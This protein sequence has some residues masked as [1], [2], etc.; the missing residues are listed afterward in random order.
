MHSFFFKNIFRKY[1]TFFLN[2]SKNKNFFKKRGDIFFKNKKLQI[3]SFPYDIQ[4]Y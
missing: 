1:I 4:E 3:I 2:Y